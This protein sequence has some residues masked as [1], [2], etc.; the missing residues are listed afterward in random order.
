MAYYELDNLT[1]Y[2]EGLPNWRYEE[3]TEWLVCKQ[4]DWDKGLFFGK[5]F[6]EFSVAIAYCQEHSDKNFVMAEV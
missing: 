1:F 4:E 2:P 5:T 3:D 6:S